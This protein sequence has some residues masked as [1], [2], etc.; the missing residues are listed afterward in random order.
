MKTLIFVAATSVV[1][2]FEDSIFDDGVSLLQVHSQKH[3]NVQA[4][5]DLP[6][7][8]PGPH[9]TPGGICDYQKSGNFP[10]DDLYGTPNL[11]Q[12]CQKDNASPAKLCN[13]F[14]GKPL[15][16]ADGE[17]LTP[18]PAPKRLPWQDGPN[19][20][21][22]GHSAFYRELWRMFEP[23]DWEQNNGPWSPT[24]N[25]KLGSVLAPE[26]GGYQVAAM[27]INM[28][29]SGWGCGTQ[30]MACKNVGNQQYAAKPS[31]M[32][33][34]TLPLAFQCKWITPKTCGAQCDREPGCTGFVVSAW[35]GQNS[36]SCYTTKVQI[37]PSDLFK[38][39]GHDPKAPCGNVSNV[40][41]PK[42]YWDFGRTGIVPRGGN[43]PG[44]LFLKD[45]PPTT[46]TTTLAPAPIT[47]PAAQPQAQAAASCPCTNG[48][49]LTLKTPRYSNLGGA[50]PDLDS[51]QEILYPEA[52]VVDGRVVHVKVWTTDPYK[53]K[54]AMNGVKGSL[55]R[56]NM[57]TNQEVAFQLSVIDADS[58]APLQLGA[59]PMTFLDL[60]EG[61][62][63]KGRA[64]VSVCNSEQFTVTPSELVLSFPEGCATA[65]SSTKGTAR[66][67]PSSVEGAL[68]DGVAS[69]RVISYIMK[70]AD[71]GI[72]SFKL[73]VAKGFGQRNFLFTLTPGAACSDES[74]LPAGCEDPL[75][76]QG[77]L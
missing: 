19:I 10:P 48:L 25:L 40:G 26:Y 51:P 64:S 37:D 1:L 67:N 16:C 8:S 66:D 39:D 52:G 77:F 70:E 41:Y 36:G 7:C 28:R 68:T 42:S 13:G 11:N 76:E 53:G 12:Y 33:C 32:R 29:Y 24:G 15:G 65:T 18:G 73:S 30:S 31:W 38:C 75:A 3:T 49:S 60:D 74:A 54:A 2:S 17:F 45:P 71:S 55:G 4:S 50:G 44:Y 22:W 43:D 5:N 20:L 69:R 34:A 35:Y 58:G 62:N 23:A 59:L 72:Y 47:T 56:L 21:S 9:N 46:T 61:K 6:N 63:G 27:N 57:K 14:T